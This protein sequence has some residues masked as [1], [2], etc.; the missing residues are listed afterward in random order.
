MVVVVLVMVDAS[1]TADAFVKLLAAG[2]AVSKPYIDVQEVHEA[3]ANEFLYDH[4]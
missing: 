2:K 1:T 4:T 3:D